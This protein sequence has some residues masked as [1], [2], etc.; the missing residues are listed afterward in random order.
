MVSCTPRARI[1]LHVQAVG[2]AQGFVAEVRSYVY[3]LPH[4]VNVKCTNM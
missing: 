1:D 2:D 4:P 3:D